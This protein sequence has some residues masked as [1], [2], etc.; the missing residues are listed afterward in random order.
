MKKVESFLHMI[1]ALQVKQRMAILQV[2]ACPKV[3]PTRLND[4]LRFLVSFS[5]IFSFSSF[6]L[7]ILRISQRRCASMK[8]R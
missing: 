5:Q 4:L 3:D 8:N 2:Y 6:K 7:N 1:S